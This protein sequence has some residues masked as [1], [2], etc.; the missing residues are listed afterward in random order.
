[1]WAEWTQLGRAWLRLRSDPWGAAACRRGSGHAERAE[2]STTA[3]DPIQGR[4][5]SGKIIEFK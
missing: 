3:A 1:M 2:H 4:A 5:V